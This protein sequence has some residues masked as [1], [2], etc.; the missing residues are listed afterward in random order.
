[1]LLELRNVAAR[2]Y[3]AEKCRAQLCMSMQKS[4]FAMLTKVGEL[5]SPNVS[6]KLSHAFGMLVSLHHKLNYC[7]ISRIIAAFGCKPSL[8]L[9]LPYNCMLRNLGNDACIACIS[10]QI[11]VSTI[12]KYRCWHL[13]LDSNILHN[14]CADV[15]LELQSSE[16]CSS[17]KKEIE[18]LWKLCLIF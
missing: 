10:S 13:A 15:C 18:E 4:L 3:L 6:S 12:L 16:L 2:A 8:F 9:N 5:C 17:L 1:M 7:W 14:I 11:R